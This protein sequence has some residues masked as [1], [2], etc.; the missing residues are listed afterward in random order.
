MVDDMKKGEREQLLAFVRL[1]KAWGIDDELR[2]KKWDA[3]ALRY[4]GPGY[5]KNR[6]AE[7]LSNSYLHYSAHASIDASEY[8][9]SL[10][11]GDPATVT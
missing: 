10:D 8:L 1:V 7:K 11:A 3:F 9:A 6:Y 4:N 5:K 2:D